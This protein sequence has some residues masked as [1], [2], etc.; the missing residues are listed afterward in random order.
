MFEAPS[1]NR[2]PEMLYCVAWK[3][4][5]ITQGELEHMRDV[6]EGEVS[7]LKEDL[8]AAVSYAYIQSTCTGHVQGNFRAKVE[9]R[10][11]FLMTRLPFTPPPPPLIKF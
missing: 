10:Q 1:L 3:D 9:Q 7:S 6:L 4:R 2:A 5:R 11:C 8:R